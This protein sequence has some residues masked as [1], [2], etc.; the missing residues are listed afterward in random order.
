MI[1]DAFACS[2]T[3]KKSKEMIG[4]NEMMREWLVTPEYGWED[5]IQEELK[6]TNGMCY[7]LK[8]GVCVCACVSHIP[9]MYEIDKISEEFSWRKAVGGRMS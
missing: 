3:I 9:F 5:A 7:F 1:R 6:H 2:K 4:K 8:C